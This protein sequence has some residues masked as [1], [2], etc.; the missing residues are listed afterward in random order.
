MAKQVEPS[1]QTKAEIARR[2]RYEPETGRFFWRVK[3]RGAK[4]EPDDEVV[5]TPCNG[6]RT[7][8]VHRREHYLHRIAIF[9]STGAWPRG[10]VDH[11]DHDKSNNRIKNL[12][13]VDATSNMRNTKLPKTNT[14]GHIGVSWNKRREKWVAQIKVNNRNISIGYFD[15]IKKA[16]EARCAASNAHN[17]H[18]NHGKALEKRNAA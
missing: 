3:V 1:E 18:P 2:I 17:F 14:S 11:I 10:D 6:Y 12:R 5:G 7:I 9:L 4:W 8:G 15:D 13:N 16:A